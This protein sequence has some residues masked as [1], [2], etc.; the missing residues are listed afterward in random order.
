MKK[1][2]AEKEREYRKLAVDLRAKL[3]LAAEDWFMNQEKKRDEELDTLIEQEWENLSEFGPRIHRNYYLRDY[4]YIL[5]NKDIIKTQSII[6]AYKAVMNIREKLFAERYH[7]P[8]AT[9][10][11]D[12]YYTVT[13]PL[14]VDFEYYDGKFVVKTT[15]YGESSI[16]P[17]WEK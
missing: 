7:S 8:D 3:D 1:I 9:Y 16:E 15:E 10:P 4:S 6:G 2:D 14:R 13:T 11:E 5:I 12:F 17:G